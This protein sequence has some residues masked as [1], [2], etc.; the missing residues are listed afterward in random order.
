MLAGNDLLCCTDFEVQY[1]AV[2]E[3]AQ[4]GVISQEQIDRSVLRIL[5]LKL[6]KGILAP[7]S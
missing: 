3:A 4:S 7:E 2:L 1:P 6:E 5:L